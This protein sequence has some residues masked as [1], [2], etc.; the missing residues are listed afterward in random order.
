MGRE[1]RRGSERERE[2][3]NISSS[4]APSEVGQ[5]TLVVP[6]S[7]TL[8]I[9]WDAPSS[10]NGLITHYDVIATP[11][12][13]V[14]LDS[15]LG[16]VSSTTLNVVEPEMVLLSILNGLVPATTYDVVLVAYTSAGGGNGTAVQLQTLESGM[17]VW[18]MWELVNITLSLLYIQNFCD[19]WIC[20]SF[21]PMFKHYI[22]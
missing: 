9:T 6:S 15:P 16:S 1:G 8:T 22:I 7:S 3:R 20:C 13:T 5:V 12:S 19:E 11:T 14:G 2:M 4:P 10:P 18:S 21:S 17:D